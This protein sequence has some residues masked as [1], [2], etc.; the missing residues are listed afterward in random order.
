MIVSRS[1]RLPRKKLLLAMGDAICTALAMVATVILRL[2]WTNG[3]DYLHGRQ[4]AIL[5]SWEVFILAFYISGLYES[6]RLQSLGK[7]VGA[8]VISVFLGALLIIGIFF[9]A[10]SIEIGRGIF[11][12]LPL[13]S[14]WLWYVCAW[15]TWPLTPHLRRSTTII[16]IF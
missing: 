8:A 3:L 11:S 10:L 6:E 5:V 12:D 7:T 2:G 4:T 1:S 16:W 13:S 14:L 9:A 15:S